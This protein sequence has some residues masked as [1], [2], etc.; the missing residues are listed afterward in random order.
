M[1]DWLSIG[2]GAASDARSLSAVSV[3]A[4]LIAEMI[5]NS[6]R[7]TIVDVV[8]G[9]LGTVMPSLMCAC[10]S[11]WYL[12]SSLMLVCSHSRFDNTR[13]MMKVVGDALLRC[14]RER[15]AIGAM[16]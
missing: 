10:N 12:C 1:S 6:G 15:A 16:S 2:V 13:S 3:N 11:T 5:R 8:D 7:F 4:L 14:S 9:S